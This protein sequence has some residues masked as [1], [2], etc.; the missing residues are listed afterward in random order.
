MIFWAYLEPCDVKRYPEITRFQAMKL[1]SLEPM[2]KMTPWQWKQSMLNGC[3]MIDEFLKRLEQP[4]IN[5]A[6]DGKSFQ[7]R[8]RCRCCWSLLGASW[9]F[10]FTLT[11]GNG[12]V[13]RRSRS[14]RRRR[15]STL[16]TL[17]LRK[18]RDTRSSR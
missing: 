4:H 5:R 17:L 16:A 12:G 10:W 11:M 8:P 13:R 7:P 18:V 1:A 6:L 3:D 14:A 9:K 2:A 15:R